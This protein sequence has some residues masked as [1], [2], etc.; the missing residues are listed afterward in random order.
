MKAEK[1]TRCNQD[2]LVLL[3]NSN[4]KM[5]ELVERI[6]EKE[7][8]RDPLNFIKQESMVDPEKVREL[9][10]VREVEEEREGD[11]DMVHEEYQDETIL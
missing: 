1:F 7:I 2:A 9:S 11:Y 8:D 6:A 5:F 3:K 10:R 4:H